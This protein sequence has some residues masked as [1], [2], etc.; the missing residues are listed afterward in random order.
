MS[1]GAPAPAADPRLANA[2]LLP[3]RDRNWTWYDYL[4]F[5]MSDVHSIGSY[6]TLGT[7]FTGGLPGLA[8]AMGLLAGILAVEALCNLVAMPSHQTGTPFPVVC[9]ASFGVRGALI[10]AFVRGMIAACWYGIQTWLASGALVVLVLHAVPS[11]APW[12]ETARHGFAGLSALG[13]AA[14]LA[15]W[16]LQAAIFWRGID[17][18][19]HFTEWA[20]P[21]IYVVMVALTVYLLARA[22]I[23]RG[24]HA[25][26]DSLRFTGTAQA[27][28]LATLVSTAMLTVSYFSAPI[29]NFGDFARYGRSRADITRGNRWG[30]PVNF[31]V[32]TALTVSTIALTGPALGVRLTDPVETV[33]RT[34][35][36]TIL[37][38]A[39]LT[40]MLATA[41]INVVV[42]FVSASFD[43]SN[44]APDRI[45]WRAAGMGS[46][47]FSVLL[48]PWNLY[49]NPVAMHLTLDV[50]ASLI[51]PLYGIL[52]ADYFVVS[53]RR[54]AVADLYIHDA[55]SCYWYR[56]GINPA[57][58]LTLCLASACANTVLFTQLASELPGLSWFV[59]CIAAAL[60]YPLLSRWYR[61]FAVREAT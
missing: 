25:I 16:L 42:N 43:F 50:L 15:L 29:L 49:N 40:F 22:G 56:N 10:P 51:G 30:L 58:L 31:L 39:I 2:A 27:G 35:N 53:R 41:G 36:T 60:G 8:V 38:L 20:G 23:G 24:L 11:L 52:V 7:L 17:A 3:T 45:S 46:A 14:F 6:V 55:T 4:S 48:T 28:T 18:I 32:F 37:V 19:R 59:G 61:G 12:A 34:D 47:L 33:A 57:A 26:A 13:W 21:A 5:W 1:G 54:I 9:R 44:L